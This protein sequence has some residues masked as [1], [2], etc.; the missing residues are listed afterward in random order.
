MLGEGAFGEVWKATYKETEN[1]VILGK[2]KNK[3]I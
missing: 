3:K 2:Q 1:N